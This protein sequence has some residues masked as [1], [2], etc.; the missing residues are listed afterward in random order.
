MIGFRTVLLLLP[1]LGG[2]VCYSCEDPNLREVEGTCVLR[3]VTLLSAEEIANVTLPSDVTSGSLKLVHG[4]VTNFSFALARKLA[5]V[6]DLTVDGMGIREL[7]VWPTWEHLSAQNNSIA[8]IAAAG[9]DLFG[10]LADAEQCQLRTLH[11]QHNA[12]TSVPSFGR[13]FRQLKVLAL[14]DNLLEIVSLERFV[15]LEQLQTLSLARNRVIQVTAG[16]S[17]NPV[18]VQLLKL[19]HLSL[20]GNRL[21]ELQVSGWEM[22]SLQSLDLSGN[23][24]YQMDVPNLGQFPALKELRYAGN[25]W[26]C[27]WLS[28]AQRYLQEK[29]I[30]VTDRELD[31]RCE[32]ENLTS[33]Q[34]MCCYEPAAKDFS[35]DLFGE[36]WEQLNGLQRRY[37]LLK[38]D[39]DKI[40]AADIN[41]I[42]ERAHGL[43]G[44]LT[45]A[46]VTGQDALESGLFRLRASVTDEMARMERLEASIDRAFIDVQQ[47]IEELYQRAT[48]PAP[49]LD[50]ILQES[51]ADSIGQIEKNI[52]HLRRRILENVSEFNLYE[53]KIRKQEDRI[54]SF[55]KS[56]AQQRKQD[57]DLKEQVEFIESSVNAVVKFLDSKYKERLGRSD[58]ID[59]GVN[60][61]GWI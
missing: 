6:K 28:A 51:L 32:Q 36:R 12:L 20:A 42:T 11:L 45:G 55:E 29:A 18:G 22:E 3:G 56:L 61:V 38:F 44:N 14:D 58:F 21:M 16:E 27:E 2:A 52:K 41:A 9:A 30:P 25:D 53:N 60:M 4:N 54:V 8:T 49:T 57:E 37:D 46:V 23:G 34:G 47:S 31:G 50:A 7:L 5:N 17:R 1:L 24:M 26:N 39:H 19:K 40:E 13:R 15:H 33:L 10:G 59:S 48:R 43:R 35:Q